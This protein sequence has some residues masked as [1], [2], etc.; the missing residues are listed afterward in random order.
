MGVEDREDPG[1]GGAAAR[2]RHRHL[3][4]LVLAELKPAVL[5]GLEDA[6]EAGLLQSPVGVG[7]DPPGLVGL[8]RALAEQ[9]NQ[10][11]GRAQDVVGGAR[12]IR[13][14]RGSSR[15]RG[16]GAH[17]LRSAVRRAD[18]V[19]AA[20]RRGRHRA[21]GG[22]VRTGS[23]PAAPG[24]SHVARTGRSSAVGVWLSMP[25]TV[26]AWTADGSRTTSAGRCRTGHRRGRS[27][28]CSRASR[29]C[30]PASPTCGR[31]PTRRSRTRPRIP[32]R[33]SGCSAR[34]AASGRRLDW[35]SARGRR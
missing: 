5:L 31:S 35:V 25:S 15:R 1:G 2:E 34:P 26:T 27:A 8:G 21:A 13:R 28:S 29:C 30:R 11:L 7:L 6:E 23:R 24:A 3:R 9:R 16:Q 17:R 4:V 32:R 12:G 20:L 14:R 33:A 18:D 19:G 10:I 22:P